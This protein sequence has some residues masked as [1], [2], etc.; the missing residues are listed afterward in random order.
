MTKKEELTKL[1]L[2]RW[3]KL[4]QLVCLQLLGG[5][6]VGCI[7]LTREQAKSAIV[8]AF[9][10]K[11]YA[12]ILATIILIGVVAGILAGCQGAIWLI[13]MIRMAKIPETNE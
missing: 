6:I 8:D 1:E 4:L 9:T 7:I 2:P 3:L 11:W 12:I 5:C 13:K 10:A